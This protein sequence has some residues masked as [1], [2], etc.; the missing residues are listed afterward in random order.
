MAAVPYRPALLL[1]I[2]FAAVS[3]VGGA[4]YTPSIP[5][6]ARAF[7]APMMSVQL[8]MTVYLVGYALAQILVGSLAD[9][10]GRRRVMLGGLA[11]F[12]A[13]S[14]AGAFAPTIDVL[15]AIRLV[16]ACGACVGLVVSRA[17]IRDCFDLSQS[18]RYMAYFGMALGVM[19]ALSPLLGGALQ[20]W[21]GWTANFLGMAAIGLAALLGTAISLRETL[22]PDK[23]RGMEPGV[24]LANYANLLRS[25]GFLAYGLALAVATAI[26]FVFLSGAPA[27]LIGGFGVSP[28]IYGFYALSM[29]TGF[30]SGN[31]LSSR[32]SHRVSFDRA[33]SY[34]FGFKAIGCALLV[35]AATM[36]GSGIGGIGAAGFVVP[37]LFIGVGAGLITPNCFAGVVRGDPSLAGTASG[38]S[39]FIQMGAA[40][41]ATLVMGAVSHDTLLPYATLQSGLTLLGAVLFWLLIRMSLRREKAVP[42]P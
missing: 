9:R 17:I 4:M 21:F 40:A 42:I 23:R 30:I 28:D 34:G 35:L 1:L 18:A 36:G 8:T 39:G 12:T 13:G 29:P 14:L 2:G 37:M 7:E 32:I 6:M 27:V 20:V 3:Q 38:L 15:I 22:P 26:F 11:I 10:F 31:F 25:P 24:F 19:P 41:L 16:Q 5:A 33:I